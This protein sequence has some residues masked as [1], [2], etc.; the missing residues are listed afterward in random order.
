VN[1]L[2]PND[3]TSVGFAQNSGSLSHSGAENSGVPSE[4]NN[5]PWS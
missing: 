2:T 5:L 4:E 3:Q 1:K